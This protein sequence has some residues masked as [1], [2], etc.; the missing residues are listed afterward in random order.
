MSNDILKDNAISEHQFLQSIDRT[1]TVSELID[2]LNKNFNIITQ[3]GIFD[4]KDTQEEEHDYLCDALLIKPHQPIHRRKHILSP[5]ENR[6]NVSWLSKVDYMCGDIAIVE[7]KRPEDESTT[8]VYMYT[9][10]KSKGIYEIELTNETELTGPIGKSGEI[11]LS[12]DTLDKIDNIVFDKLNVDTLNVR[13][14]NLNGDGILSTKEIIT[15]KLQIGN[16]IFENTDGIN[17]TLATDELQVDTIIGF[18]GLNPETKTVTFGSQVIMDK[19][20]GS[21]ENEQ[22][23]FETGIRTNLISSK[24]ISDNIIINSPISSD[25]D[26]LVFNKNIKTDSF[27]AN[28]DSKI[29]FNSKISISEIESKNDNIK[30]NVP[31][32]VDEISSNLKNYIKINSD[33]TGDNPLNFDVDVNLKKNVNFNESN[34]HF[35]HFDFSDKLISGQIFLGLNNIQ[36]IIIPDITLDG[37]YNFSK[38]GQPYSYVPCT[39]RYGIARVKKNENEWY[40]LISKNTKY[41]DIITSDDDGNKSVRI[42][43]TKSTSDN[44]VKNENIYDLISANDMY[45]SIFN[46][47]YNTDSTIDDTLPILPPSKK[48][49]S[50]KLKVQSNTE[51]T[52]ISIGFSK[53][54]GYFETLTNCEIDIVKI[55]QLDY[56]GMIGLQNI[57]YYMTLY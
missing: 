36:K 55:E 25:N 47:L 31:I 42:F 41:T 44:I 46:N 14:I 1:D 22:T 30:I 53:Y 9:I 3:T 19:V 29:T 50:K 21:N 26:D 17:S 34:L 27:S 33:I 38:F 6:K 8:R 24:N 7:Q 32:K 23:T 48:S 11:N 37:T 16:L 54:N 20:S 40:M 49:V 57:F 2:K 43:T 4:I 52:D 12:Q 45:K 56:P 28:E 10:Q 15:N 18:S 39:G 5:N 51:N 35:Q 13:S